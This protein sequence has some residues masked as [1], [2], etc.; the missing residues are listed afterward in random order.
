MLNELTDRIFE[1][2]INCRYKAYL[3]FC[4]ESGVSTD[5]ERMLR[6]ERT[7]ERT[8][9]FEKLLYRSG[10]QLAVKNETL[11]PTLLKRKAQYV[12]MSSYKRNGIYTRFDGLKLVPGESKLG[13]FFYVPIL[14]PPRHWTRKKQK[15][16]L[17]IYACLLAELQGVLPKRGIV[18]TGPEFRSSSMAL[19]PALPFARK[20]FQELSDNGIASLSSSMLLNEHCEICEFRKR[21]HDQALTEDNVS[22]LRGMGEKEVTRLIRNGVNTVTRLAQTFRPRRKGKRKGIVKRRYHALQAMAVRDKN[23]ICTGLTADFDRRGQHIRGRR[24]DTKRRFRLP[25]WCTC[26]CKGRHRG[27]SFV[28]GK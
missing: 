2:Y 3:Q 21:C 8:A 14:V 11:S 22:L 17:A 26:C 4:G 23:G 28:L 18:L 15:H 13:D 7:S 12:L 20:A 1:S 16:L 25:N 5:F 24:V 6:Q 19:A 27:N 9:A 10:L